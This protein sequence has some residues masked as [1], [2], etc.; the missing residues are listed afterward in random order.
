MS[1]VEVTTTPE[2]LPVRVE[3]TRAALRYGAAFVS[4]QVLRQCR[5]AALAGGLARRRE[6]EA[7]GVAPAT[8]T[9]LGVPT[10]EQAR[11]FEAGRPAGVA[12]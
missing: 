11:A 2:G 10:Q 7:L 1:G 9:E 5:A 8:L 3:V 6:L 4:E 12:R